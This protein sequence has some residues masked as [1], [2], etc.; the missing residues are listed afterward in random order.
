MLSGSEPVPEHFGLETESS[1]VPKRC[2][3]LSRLAVTCSQGCIR[4]GASAV[5]GSRT[6]CAH[7]ACLGSIQRVGAPSVEHTR[8]SG[9]IAC[10]GCPRQAGCC[11]FGLSGCQA[12]FPGH[13]SCAAGRRSAA[14][15]AAI[16]RSGAR[17]G[18]CGPAS[19]ARSALRECASRGG[20]ERAC[21]AFRAGAQRVCR[22]GRR[23]GARGGRRGRNGRRRTADVRHVFA[24]QHGQDDR[25]AGEQLR[26]GA[27]AAAQHRALLLACQQ[28]RPAARPARRGLPGLAQYRL[29]QR[30]LARRDVVCQ[31]AVQPGPRCA[32]VA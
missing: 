22:S 8:T 5:K 9:T 24:G 31:L 17:H 1:V 30:R 28:R 11:R 20:A 29:A 14:A 15:A 27:R 32:A 26:A 2:R 16:A 21:S 13:A 19:G 7:C 3:Q 6:A 4:L 25:A 18:A 23:H 10:A 12:S